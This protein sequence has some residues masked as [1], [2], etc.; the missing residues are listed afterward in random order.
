M[1]EIINATFLAGCANI[2]QL[3]HDGGSISEVETLCVSTII[4]DMNN[5]NPR[6][7]ILAASALPSG[8]T[9]AATVETIE[10]LI[11]RHKNKYRLFLDYC[12]EI[13]VNVKDFPQCEEI[14]LKKMAAG[15]VDVAGSSPVDRPIFVC[16][17][18]MRWAL[19]PI[20]ALPKKLA[21]WP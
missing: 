14:S 6:T 10:Y 7:S 11:E 2:R 5:E 21:Q 17:W 12:E 4:T 3:G 18:I 1:Q 15:S 19:A 13:G 8:K 20:S 9:A 16:M